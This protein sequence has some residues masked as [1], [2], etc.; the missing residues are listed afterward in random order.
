MSRLLFEDLIVIHEE[1]PRPKIECTKLDHSY[2]V[3]DLHDLC[4]CFED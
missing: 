4:A 1:R 3:D 2:G